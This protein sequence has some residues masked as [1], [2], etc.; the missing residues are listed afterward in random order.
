MLLI[1]IRLRIWIG[2]TIELY[3]L[4]KKMPWR[5]EAPY[6]SY[7]FNKSK[8]RAKILKLIVRLLNLMG[9]IPEAMFAFLLSGIILLAL[10]LFD[11]T[12]LIQKYF[13]SL[14]LDILVFGI[15]IVVFNKIWE[16]RR[17][18]RRWQEEIHDY[19]GWNEP[20]AK[21]RIVGN[22]K[23]L[24]RNRI[25]KIDLEGC[26]LEG[27]WLEGINLKGASLIGASLEGARL[28]GIN[29]EG[30]QLEAANFRKA[31]LDRANLQGAGL[32]GASLNDARLWFANL[33]RAWNR[34]ED[35]VWCQGTDFGHANLQY[36]NFA[37]GNFQRADFNNADLQNSEFN[38]CALDEANFSHADMRHA[39]LIGV[40]LNKANFANANFQDGSLSSYYEEYNHGGPFHP[41]TKLC[42]ANLEE[43]NLSGVDFHEA[44]LS[45][46]NFKK[47]DLRGAKN[48]TIEQLSKAKTLYLAKLDPD[49]EKE[50]KDKFPHL[51]EATADDK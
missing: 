29:L 36:V 5:L 48:L 25:T 12:D 41:L 15:L 4:L 11:N 16:K 44:D 27:A 45:G 47:A 28:G 42:E 40:T 21:F 3:R 2:D 32:T 8:K 31:E 17:N 9:A 7:Y 33:R 50:L 49:V 26:F 34:G 18:I 22:I 1:F 51:L 30:A 24:N 19:S 43:A 46:A 14:L 39:S 6:S 13:P 20:E 23:R 38:W 37:D 10:Y 35:E